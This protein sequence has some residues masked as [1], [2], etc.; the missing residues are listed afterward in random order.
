MASLLRA[1]PDLIPLLCWIG[2]KKQAL[3]LHET[4]GV[5]VH[6][7]EGEAPLAGVPTVEGGRLALEAMSIAA[8]LCDRGAFRAVVTGP[9]SKTWAQA[10][11]LRHPGQT[12]FF[13]ER[14]AGEPTMA[15][16]SDRLKVA[17]VTWHIPLMDVWQHLTEAAMRRCIE[18]LAA[19]LQRLGMA[20]P[21]IAVCGLNPHAGEGG[22]IGR[23]ELEVLDPML[24]R[25]A[26][27]HYE[28]SSCQPADTV[29]Y[30]H[31]EGEFDGVVALY[32]D[33]ALA[34]VKTIAFHEAVNVTLGLRHL[35]TSPDHGTAFGIAGKGVAR[36]DSMLAAVELALRASQVNR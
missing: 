27:A 15:F 8:E 2:P 32:H 23:E 5:P 9:I 36:H 12:E 20:R 22:L 7:L 26:C 4:F 16:A 6:G 14:W 31:L 18:N 19:F 3:Q 30:R 11:G 17:L 1:R 28:L 33:Q 13:A 25:F 10:A 35:R 21:R 24:R 29:F 34:P